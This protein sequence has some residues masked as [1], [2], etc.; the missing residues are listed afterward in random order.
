MAG[1]TTYK[2]TRKKK[3][4]KK[5][6][7]KKVVKKV[8]K[9]TSKKRLNAVSDAIIRKVGTVVASG[10]KAFPADFN[11]QMMYINDAKDMVRIA[12]M[13]REDK[14]KAAVNAASRMDTAARDELPASFFTLVKW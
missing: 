3:P 4:V 1:K 11:Q 9:P 8:V 7:K 12:K 5:V 6:T 2:T 14:L 10:C 13:V